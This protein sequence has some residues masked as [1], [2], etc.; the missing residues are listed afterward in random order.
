MRHSGPLGRSVGG[1]RFQ[2][3]VLEDALQVVHVVELFPF[4]FL[5]VVFRIVAEDALGEG[6]QIGAFVG[7]VGLQFSRCSSYQR[8]LNKGRSNCGQ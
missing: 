4:G 1:M 3:A 7:S 2:P 5:H 6:N 8:V